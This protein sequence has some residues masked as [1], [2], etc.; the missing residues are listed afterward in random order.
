M[1]VHQGVSA[2]GTATVSEIVSAEPNPSGEIYAA[3]NLMFSRSLGRV[4]GGMF[5]GSFLKSEKLL[6]ED[7]GI[8]VRTGRAGNVGKRAGNGCRRLQVETGICP[9]QH[10]ALA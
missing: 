9:T 7:G 4:K 5:A 1:H 10:Q 3:R 6:R 8:C 2:V